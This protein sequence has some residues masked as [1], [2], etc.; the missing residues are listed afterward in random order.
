MR[1]EDLAQEIELQE[2]MR[3]QQRAIQ[4]R[5]A[6]FSH[7]EDCGDEI[8]MLRRKITGVTRCITCQQEFE[9]LNK[10]GRL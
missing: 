9:S 6:S 7:C 2:Y 1:P 3:T 4:P 5:R 8:P 10:R